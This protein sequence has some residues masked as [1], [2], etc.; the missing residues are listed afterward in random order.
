MKDKL[1]F[2]EACK[3]LQLS[4][5][6]LEQA[7]ANG[8]ISAIKEGDSIFFKR[9]IVNKFKVNR[10]TEPTIILADEDMDILE[11]VEEIDLS[12]PKPVQK[13]K[14]AEVKAS[15]PKTPELEIPDLSGSLD[16]IVIEPR[17]ADKGEAKTPTGA[18]PV[19]AGLGSPDETVLNL[20]GLLED[21]GSEGTTPIPGAPVADKLLEESSDITVEG[22]V[23]DETLLDT[24]L[25]EVGE[26]EDSFKM[27]T[28]TDAGVV[29]PTEANLLRGGEARA[30]QMKRKKSHG[31]LTGLLL[32]T[33]IVL[34]VP[35]GI[36]LNLFFV[37]SDTPIVSGPAKSEPVYQWI[38]DVNKLGGIVEMISDFF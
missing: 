23:S 22:N 11:G 35:L 3:E 7:V 8:E 24:D 12:G 18:T 21:D 9:E 17:K 13:P 14:A 31:A 2:E 26:E 27:E 16:D 28:T 6:E 34:L 10:K 33:S 29:E 25:L 19:Q 32:A 36:C 4:E 30:M 38:F 15:E 1:N 37:S 20:D 5:D